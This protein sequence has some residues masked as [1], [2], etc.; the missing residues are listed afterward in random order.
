[1]VT[2]SKRAPK[3][4]DF[5]EIVGSY[6]VGKGGIQL[7]E[8][9][10]K[11]WLS[12]GA[13]PSG[14]VHNMLVDAKIIEGAKMDVSAKSK[15]NKEVE[16]ASPEPAKEAGGEPKA[17]EEKEGKVLEAKEKSEEPKKK[18]KAEEEK[19]EEVKAVEKEA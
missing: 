8:D 4:G 10:I 12:S 5:V 13:R 6:D 7:K 3:S 2:E 18:E 19:P 11:H 9:R 1:V 15:K 14:T 17:T 16:S